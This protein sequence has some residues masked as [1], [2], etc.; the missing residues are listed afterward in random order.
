MTITTPHTNTFLFLLHSIDSMTRIEDPD[1]FHEV[2]AGIH[3]MLVEATDDERITALE[4]GA[5]WRDLR[6]AVRG[7]TTTL[8]FFRD[9]LDTW[10]AV[11]EVSEAPP[12]RAF[13][14]VVGFTY[15]EGAD[16]NAR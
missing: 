1:T 6:A 16:Q 5:L 8:G 13:G 7:G 3:D 9:W 4:S 12:I 2:E 10:T 11:V 15:D 14:Y